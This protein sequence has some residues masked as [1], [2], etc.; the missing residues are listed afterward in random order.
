MAEAGA[1]LGTLTIRAAQ[2]EQAAEGPQSFAVLANR[3]LVVAD[4]LRRRL[5]VFDAGGAFRRS[6]DVGVPVDDV[7]ALGDDRL[8]LTEAGRPDP[9]AISLTGERLPALAVAAPAPQLEATLTSERTGRI[10][11]PVGAAL[12]ASAAPPAI[13]VQIQQPSLRMASLQVI[14]STATHVYVA[15]ESAASAGTSLA[16]LGVIVRRYAVDGG[17]DREVRNISTDYYVP[18]R[19]P[20]RIADDT[21]YQLFPASDAVQIRVWDLR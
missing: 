7:V 13:A 15:I 9:F 4:P 11:M 1:S 20:F 14:A 16:S 19:T 3:D 18:P 12:P 10:Q 21:L 5:V 17:F 8:R 6:I 2:P